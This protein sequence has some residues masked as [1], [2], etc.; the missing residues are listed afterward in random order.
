MQENG[1]GSGGGTGGDSGGERPYRYR[2]LV[3]ELYLPSADSRYVVDKYG[4][5]RLRRRHR[6]RHIKG[7]LVM[8]AIT[9]VLLVVGSN[10]H[11]H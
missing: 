5:R 2:D 10:M 9:V 7:R 3:R 4:R 1:Y 11:H 6:S 8:L